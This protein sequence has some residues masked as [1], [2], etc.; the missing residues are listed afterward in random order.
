MHLKGYFGRVS[1]SIPATL[2]LPGLCILKV[3]VDVFLTAFQY[4]LMF[5]LKA[6]VVI[7]CGT[8]MGICSV[9]IISRYMADLLGLVTGN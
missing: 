4:H 9:E 5:L 6:H 2:L 1:D 8:L 7:V 3:I